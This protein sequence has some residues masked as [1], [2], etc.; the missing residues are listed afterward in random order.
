MPS[1]T[2]NILSRS[3]SATTPLSSLQSQ[4]DHL[5]GGFVEQATDL[6]TLAAISAGG[7]AFRAGRVGLMGLGTGNAVQAL[8]YVGGLGAEV[9]A[10]EL[11]SRGIA[12]LSNRVL[13]PAPLQPEN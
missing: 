13:G 1:R 10:F 9:S 8:S 11:T 6:R 2:N 5:V 12:S 3:I 7:L 4:V